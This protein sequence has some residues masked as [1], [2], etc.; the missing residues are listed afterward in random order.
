MRLWPPDTLSWPKCANNAID[1]TRVLFEF[2]FQFD[3]DGGRVLEWWSQCRC[4]EVSRTC[5]R[6]RATAHRRHDLPAFASLSAHL[7]PPEPLLHLLSSST[8]SI[9]NSQRVAF[10]NTRVPMKAETLLF[11]SLFRFSVGFCVF[12]SFIFC[13]FHLAVCLVFG[14]I[15]WS[16]RR[17]RRSRNQIQ[18]HCCTTSAQCSVPPREKKK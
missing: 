1:S 10:H 2:E 11:V 13:Y 16:A 6:S 17:A 4:R 5:C 9:S 8:P 15:S 12:F 7:A 14:Q 3:I 18:F